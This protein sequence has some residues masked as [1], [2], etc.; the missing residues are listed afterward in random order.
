M[1]G[2][3]WYT[4][5]VVKRLVEN[6]PEHEFVFFFDRAFDKRFVF[7]KNVEPVVLFPPARHPILFKWFFNYSIKNLFSVPLDLYEYHCFVSLS[8]VYSVK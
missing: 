8:N 5:E 4:F 7:G 3:G 2:F 6:H 1:E